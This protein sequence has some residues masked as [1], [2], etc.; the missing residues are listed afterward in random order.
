[1]ANHR[2]Y[3]RGFLDYL[4]E[5]DMPV[6]TVTPSQVEQYLRHAIGAFKY[7]MADLRARDGICSRARIHA[8]LRLAQGQWPPEPEVIGPD[9]ALRLCDLPRIRDLVA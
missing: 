1:M 7:A 3:A 2:N 6:T 8:L 9:A 5:R 4:A